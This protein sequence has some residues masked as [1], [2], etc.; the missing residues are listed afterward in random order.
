[1]DLWQYFKDLFKAEQESSSV[2]PYINEP[3]E[4]SEDE[5]ERYEHWKR[6]LA[7]QRLLEWLNTQYATFTISGESEIDK[8][9]D[10][11]NTPSSKGFVIHFNDRF[12]NRSNIIHLFDYLKER[13]LEMNYKLYMSD[14][15]TYNKTRNDKTWVE[16]I[17]RHYLKPRFKVLEDHTFDQMFGNIRVELLFRNDEI[18]NL[19]F[20]AT[21]YNDRSYKEAN[22]FND[23]MRELLKS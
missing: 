2:K 18:R 8:T 15:R 1:M 16:T 21:R 14:I 4:R 10:F 12:H 7:K 23:L 13:V 17:E 9:I 19:K 22:T 3:L 5:K 11:L 20:S 6:T